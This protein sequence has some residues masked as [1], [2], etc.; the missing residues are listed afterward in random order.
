MHEYLFE[1]QKALEEAYLQ[2]Y[3]NEFG[4]D[5]DRFERDRKSPEVERRTKRDLESGEH[6]GVQGTPTFFVNGIRHDG[7]YDL[8]NPARGN[9][10]EHKTEGPP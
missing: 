2:R 6:S 5:L 3:A 1:H 7:G 9:R 8:Q 4:L 10:R